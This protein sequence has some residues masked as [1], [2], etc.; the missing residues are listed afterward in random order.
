MV[1][2][3]SMNV[4]RIYLRIIL[5][6]PTFHVFSTNAILSMRLLRITKLS[7]WSGTYLATLTMI[8]NYSYNK[9]CHFFKFLESA[10]TRMQLEN[11]ETR[12]K[13]ANK[14]ED[15][16]TIVKKRQ[17]KLKIV[18][19]SVLLFSVRIFYQFN[20]WNFMARFMTNS[21]G[22]VCIWSKIRSSK[23]PL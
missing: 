12:W 22:L 14:L 6:W 9:Y 17:I 16:L 10:V 21:Y 13:I 23:Y 2:G 18:D 20:N 5:G 15:P 19:V 1:P 7:L 3:L 11:G 8:Q 4:E